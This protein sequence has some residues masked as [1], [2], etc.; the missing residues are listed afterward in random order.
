VN[1]RGVTVR[2]V[3]H[4]AGLGEVRRRFGGADLPAVLAGLLAAVG[5]L[6][7]VGGIAGAVGRIGYEYG[8]EHADG[9][10]LTMG[11]FLAGVVVLLVS[12]FV[13]GWVAGRVARYDGGGNGLGA[14]LLFVLRAAGLAALGAWAGDEYDV[15]DNVELPQ[16]FRDGDYT[17]QAVA[18]GVV[19]VLVALLAGW[20]GGKAGE[21]YHRKAD[22]VIVATRPGGVGGSTEVRGTGTGGQSGTDRRVLR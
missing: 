10:D 12:F 11:G 21:R 16:W 9:D 3:G 14:A 22:E 2:P 17:G 5:T 7:L 15:F 4:D 19:G 1:A 8:F 6:V 20:I 13:G 18:S